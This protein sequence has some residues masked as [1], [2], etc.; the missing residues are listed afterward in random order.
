MRFTVNGIWKVTGQPT[1]MSIEATDPEAAAD[2]A[3]RRGL[4]VRS[5][6]KAKGIGPTIGPTFEEL[7]YARYVVSSKTSFGKICFGLLLAGAGIGASWYGYNIAA[8]SPGGG[9]YTV[10]WGLVIFG[11]YT[12]FRG[13]ASNSANE[14]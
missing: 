6:E 10:Y 13:A 14:Q 3:L 4:E 8:S 9:H 2:N 7:E 12:A 11:L 1:T 5:V